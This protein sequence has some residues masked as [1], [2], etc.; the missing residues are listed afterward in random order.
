M[1][2]PEITIHDAHQWGPTW[3]TTLTNV[4]DKGKAVAE[5]ILEMEK[6][7]EDDQV[8][9]PEMQNLG[10]TAILNSSGEIYSTYL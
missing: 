8:S 2:L 3:T 10:V 7:S 6:D 9:S 1:N 4:R 5:A